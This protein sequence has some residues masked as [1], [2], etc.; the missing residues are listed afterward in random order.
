VD[1][2]SDFTSNA[3][4]TIV[5]KIGRQWTVVLIAVLVALAIFLILNR[6]K[7]K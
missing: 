4:G 7:S 6:G 5:D 2:L 1:W 3:F